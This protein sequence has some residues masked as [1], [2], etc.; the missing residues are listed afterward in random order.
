MNLLAVDTSGLGCSVALSTGDR[1]L[2]E[3]NLRNNETHS[4][5]LMTIVESLM[6]VSGMNPSDIDA[7]AVTRGPGSFTGLRIGLSTVKGLSLAL[8]KQVVGVSSLDALARGISHMGQKNICAMIDARKDEVFTA[9]YTADGPLLRKI[10]EERLVGMADL[11]T[12]IDEETLFVG[13][14]A[15]RYRELIQTRVGGRA[16]FPE[17]S[18]NHVRAEIVASIGFTE[19]IDH[20]EQNSTDISACYIRKSDAEIHRDIHEGKTAKV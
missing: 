9:L 8:G 3:L 4:K 20:A 1:L 2:A 6:R 19:L 14:G 11:A 5:H 16:V 10:S 17:D 15:E 18:F 7:L 13:S 12:D